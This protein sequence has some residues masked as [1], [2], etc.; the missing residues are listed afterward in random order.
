MKGIK[1]TEVIFECVHVCYRIAPREFQKATEFK[2]A[3]LDVAAKSW[4]RCQE[5][6]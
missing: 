6:D 4:C 2:E 3:L 5:T 1:W